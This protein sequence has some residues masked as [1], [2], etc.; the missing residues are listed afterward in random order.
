VFWNAA[1]LRTSSVNT[2]SAPTASIGEL[3]D[4]VALPGLPI[5]RLSASLDIMIM[6]KIGAPWEPER[7]LGPIADGDAPELVVNESIPNEVG[8]DDSYV[9][10]EAAKQLREIERGARST[11]VVA[12]RSRCGDCS[13]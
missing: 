12:P 11:L 10:K 13:R 4:G 2:P 7:A 6:R 1:R 5:A 9:R 8:K 3:R